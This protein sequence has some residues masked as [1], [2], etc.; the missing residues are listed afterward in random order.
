MITKT[1]I[2][3]IKRGRS[4]GKD[5]VAALKSDETATRSARSVLRATV[6]AWV[7][8]FQQQRRTEPKRAFR[9]LFGE[10]A[11]HPGED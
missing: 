7:R 10:Q 9:S 1:S 5:T 4:D 11:S 6:S 3:V 2:R 8:E